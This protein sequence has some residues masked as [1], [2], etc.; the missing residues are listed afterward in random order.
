M[1]SY[2]VTSSSII[3][4]TY[5]AID[6]LFYWMSNVTLFIVYRIESY[7]ITLHWHRYWT[8]SIHNCKLKVPYV[9]QNELQWIKKRLRQRRRKSIFLFKMKHVQHGPQYPT[10]LLGN[11]FKTY[12]EKIF[13][14][15]RLNKF[16]GFEL[17]KIISLL[18][19]KN[20]V[21]NL[22][23]TSIANLSQTKNIS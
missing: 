3:C 9:V 8:L 20:T 6:V 15:S 22:T 21:S 16:I 1:N 11:E 14:N 19:R 10:T 4:I 7:R 17:Q 23:L 12:G 5:G 2:Q 13:Y 18:E